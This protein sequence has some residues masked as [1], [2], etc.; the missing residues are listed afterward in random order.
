MSANLFSAVIV[1]IQ[2]DTGQHSLYRV[3][4]SGATQQVIHSERLAMVG[5]GGQVW[6]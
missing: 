2:L 4:V 3:W 6:Q 1:K 5:R